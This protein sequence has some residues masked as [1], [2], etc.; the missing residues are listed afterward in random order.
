VS[1][2]REIEI[3]VELLRELLGDERK[4]YE[5]KGQISFDCPVCAAE[6][7]LDK[8]DGKGNLEINYIKHIYKCWSCGETHETHGG[9]GKLISKFGSKKQRKLYDLI[10]PEELKINEKEYKKLKLPEG[11]TL[12]KDINRKYPPHLQ[13]LRYLEQRGVTKD[14]IEKYNIGL[15]T[16]GNFANRIIIPSYDV[17]KELNYFIARAWGKTKFKYMNPEAEKDKIIFNEHL[18]DWDKDIYVVE[19]AFDSIFLDNSV[20]ML[21]KTMSKLLFETIYTKA[22]GLI[23]ICLDGDAWENSVKLYRELNGGILWNRIK[24]VHLPLDKDIAD[25]RGNI[26]DYYVE[27]KD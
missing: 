1:D 10:K 27:M 22:K 3:L 18:I 16:E 21:G 15:T 19:G 13:G 23:T 14:I 5:S 20:P 24:V 9:L 2:E 26:N 4:H 7:G 12:I 11:F 17:N 8:G 6:K 25:L